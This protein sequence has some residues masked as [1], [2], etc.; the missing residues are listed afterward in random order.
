MKPAT[1]LAGHG[2]QCEYRLAD[3]GGDEE[4]G[5]PFYLII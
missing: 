5:G 3:A 4:T 2:A 1:S